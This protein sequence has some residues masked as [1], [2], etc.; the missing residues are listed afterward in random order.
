MPETQE[1]RADTT[2][3]QSPWEAQRAAEPAPDERP[4]VLVGAAFLGGFVVAQ[5]LKKLGG[6]DD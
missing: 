2:T 5:I 1:T 4:E 3:G 6:S